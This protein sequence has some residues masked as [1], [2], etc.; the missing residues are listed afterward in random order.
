MGE[1]PG[2]GIR[3]GEKF[4]AN[5]PGMLELPAQTAL[6]IREL[7]IAA[8]VPESFVLLSDQKRPRGRRA[9]ISAPGVRIGNGRVLSKAGAGAAAARGAILN[10]RWGLVKFAGATNAARRRHAVCRSNI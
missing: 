10:K 8:S 3:R 4:L 7:L 5:S 2:K 6:S 1:S 9:S